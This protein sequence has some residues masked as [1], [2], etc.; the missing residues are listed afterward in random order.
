MALSTAVSVAILSANR[1]EDDDISCRHAERL[2]NHNL[3]VAAPRPATLGISSS[4][5]R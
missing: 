5:G 4:S 3:N 1:A 2:F